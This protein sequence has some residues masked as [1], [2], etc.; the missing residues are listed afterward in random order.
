MEQP[1]GHRPLETCGHLVRTPR[2]PVNALYHSQFDFRRSRLR[3]G[4]RHSNLYPD[5]ETTKLW[6]F[7]M[8]LG[9][10]LDCPT[11]ARQSADG[12]G[13]HT[14]TRPLV[15]SGER[16]FRSQETRLHTVISVCTKAPTQLGQDKF[17]C[18][19]GGTQCENLN[20]GDSLQAT[21]RRVSDVPLGLAWISCWSELG[22][23]V[24]ALPRHA[25]TAALQKR[26]SQEVQY[27]TS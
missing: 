16:W 24:T 7:D 8:T 18:F 6:A 1:G 23:I 21:K 22:R 11:Q 5:L 26:S 14:R 19:L 4:P 13:A 12:P 2:H 27:R 25:S 15:H 17:S 3:L 10:A 9:I 20:I